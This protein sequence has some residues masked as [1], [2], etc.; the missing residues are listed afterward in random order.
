[1]GSLSSKTSAE[2]AAHRR[3]THASADRL[4]TEFLFVAENFFL[5]HREQVSYVQNTRSDSQKGVRAFLLS[6]SDICVLTFAGSFHLTHSTFQVLQVSAEGGGTL[7][8]SRQRGVEDI[9][10]SR[11]SFESFH[12]F[13][14]E[15]PL[16]RTP[17]HQRR[18][19]KQLLDLLDC[20]GSRKHSGRRD[21]PDLLEREAADGWNIDAEGAQHR[22]DRALAPEVG[23]R[24]LTRRG[25]LNHAPLAP[26]APQNPAQ[27]TPP[28]VLHIGSPHRTTVLGA[29][30]EG[31]GDTMRA[32]DFRVTVPDANTN[33]VA[34]APTSAPATPMTAQEAV[35]RPHSVTHVLPPSV[36]ARLPVAA[37]TTCYTTAGAV[38]SPRGNIEGHHRHELV[39][40]PR[41]PE[42]QATTETASL[43]PTPRGG[44]TSPRTP[45]GGTAH[46]LPQS[47]PQVPGHVQPLTPR[48]VY[49]QG[50]TTPRTH[51]AAEPRG[52]RPSRLLDHAALPSWD[53][54][55][56][57]SPRQR[58]GGAQATVYSCNSSTSAS[59]LGASAMSLTGALNMPGVRFNPDT[60]QPIPALRGGSPS[61]NSPTDSSGV[62]A[63]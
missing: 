34:P 53:Y 49:V 50:R 42:A 60:L 28:S 29:E 17:R 11:S 51:A 54:L 62:S 55:Q 47:L 30:T 37:S 7:T 26:A 9:E 31:T 25:L 27:L 5:E 58:A 57:F 20:D 41:R 15:T 14:N 13:P 43:E 40:R 44:R 19:R 16:G 21:T 18:Q 24:S 12:P 3:T 52:A 2:E 56:H 45:R 35:P 4:Q 48:G 1:M 61:K 59:E 22:R 46:G 33:Q 38:S 23:S 6:V 10:L 39:S 63:A 8:S 32:C 36:G